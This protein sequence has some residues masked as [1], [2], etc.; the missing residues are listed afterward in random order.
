[1]KQTHKQRLVGGIVLLSLALIFIPTILDFSQDELAPMQREAMPEAPNVMKMEVLPLEI[2]SGRIDP[3]VD[4]D[5]RIIETPG[6]VK[7]TAEKE[8]SRPATPASPK[9]E[10]KTAAKPVVSKVESKP[11]PVTKAAV[12]AAT[13][14]WVV[15]VASFADETKAFTLRDRLR[16][17]GITSFIERGHG[18]AGLTYRVKVG[19]VLRKSEADQLKKQVS[20]QFK[21]DGLVMRYH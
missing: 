21:L 19:P 15:Q 8:S 17:S 13:S 12:T 20:Q 16:G 5:S 2:W 6:A 11:K 7:S 10:A 14:A 9:S 4:S 3:E 18:G 1:M